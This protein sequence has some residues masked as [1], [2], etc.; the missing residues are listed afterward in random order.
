MKRDEL[1]QRYGNDAAVISVGLPNLPEVDQ[2]I[3]VQ[4]GELDFREWTPENRDTAINFPS[5]VTK[6]GFALRISDFTRTIV[7]N[8]E[9]TIEGKPALIKTPVKPLESALQQAIL[10]AAKVAK[11]A[12]S[13][14]DFVVEFYTEFFKQFGIN[15]SDDT[16]VDTLTLAFKVTEKT[17]IGT[18]EGWSYP[19]TRI[20][21]QKV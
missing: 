17:E 19:A 10:Q 18:P 21:A 11:V 16:D 9:T 13:K 4:F 15:V 2:I 7:C 1:R 6:E 8:V 5:L 14:G 3:T 12:K 20:K